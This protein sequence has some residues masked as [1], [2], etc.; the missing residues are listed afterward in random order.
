MAD[1]VILQSTA[2]DQTKDLQDL[3]KGYQKRR[4]QVVEKG[5]EELRQVSENYQNR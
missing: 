1:K 4:Q 5:E 3:Y 2:S